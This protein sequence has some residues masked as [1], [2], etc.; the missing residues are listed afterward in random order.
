MLSHQLL[1]DKLSATETWTKS[2]AGKQAETGGGTQ[3]VR[4]TS[5]GQL[6]DQELVVEH[7]LTGNPAEAAAGFGRMAW[8]GNAPPWVAQWSFSSALAPFAS[9]T[10]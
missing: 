1:V 10:A 3:R 8:P 5:R 7:D 6:I 4:C 2:R 9:G